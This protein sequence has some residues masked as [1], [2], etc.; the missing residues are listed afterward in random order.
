MKSEMKMETTLYVGNLP[1]ETTEQDLHNLFAQIGMVNEILLMKDRDTGRSRGFAY[2]TM[3]SQED[4]KKAVEQNNERIVYNR[5]LKV[6]LA[7]PREQRSWSNYDS[8]QGAGNQSNTS[9][10]RTSGIRH[11]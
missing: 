8:N 7:H 9:R 4:A 11:Y 10:N 6:I 2:V 3:N 1:F 5:E